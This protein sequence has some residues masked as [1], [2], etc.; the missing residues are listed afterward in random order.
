MQSKIL[1]VEDD[2]ALADS[3]LNGFT[4][5]GYSIFHT[6][7]GIAGYEMASQNEF[8]VMILDIMLPGNVHFSSLFRGRISIFS[9]RHD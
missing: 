4:N 6:S 7:D 8:D 5:S 1:L 9:F 2:I 3:I